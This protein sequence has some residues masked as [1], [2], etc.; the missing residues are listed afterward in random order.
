MHSQFLRMYHNPSLTVS[1]QLSLVPG[2]PFSYGPAGAAL[3]GKA[4]GFK[5]PECDD[6]IKGPAPLL[7]AWPPPAG[8]GEIMPLTRPL[9]RPN[10]AP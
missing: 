8:G 4:R 6:P 2:L 7:V 10:R 1:E 9:R 3:P 5:V